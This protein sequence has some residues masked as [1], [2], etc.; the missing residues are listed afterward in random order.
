MT[1]R[2]LSGYDVDDNRAQKALDAIREFVATFE[3]RRE[4]GEPRRLVTGES[5]GGGIL[6]QAPEDFTEH[7]LI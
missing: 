5:L 3:S 6:E 1:H 2:D 7:E 4:V